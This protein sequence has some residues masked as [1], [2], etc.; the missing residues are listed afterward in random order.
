MTLKARCNNPKS[1]KYHWYWERWIK[2]LRKSYEDF[3]RDMWDSYYKHIEK[4]WENN[5]QIDRIDNN[6]NYCKEN[7]RRVTIK[8][9]CRNRSSNHLVELNWE[10]MPLVEAY[11]KWNPSVSFSVFQSRIYINKLDD[12]IDLALHGTKEEIREYLQLTK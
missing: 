7:C 3:K 2:C 10:I 11:E 5:T 8:E 4:Y 1:H 9:N 12:N 6:W